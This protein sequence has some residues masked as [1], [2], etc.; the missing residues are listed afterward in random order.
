MPVPVAASPATAP[1]A[2]PSCTHGGGVRLIDQ[3]REHVS[4]LIDGLP[5]RDLWEDRWAARLRHEDVWQ[6]VRDAVADDRWCEPAPAATH[7]GNSSD[8]GASASIN[9]TGNDTGNNTG[10][11]T[12]VQSGDQPPFQK[13][14]RLCAP[15]S[16]Q[17]QQTIGRFING[18]TFSATLAGRADGCA[19]LVIGVPSGAQRLTSSGRQTTRMSVSSGSP[20]GKHVSVQI[21]SLASGTR[22]TIL[23]TS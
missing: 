21:D 11:D 1:G 23:W 15:T 19:D 12:G 2:P 20:L 10:N 17:D 7:R 5:V 8:E 9:N 14:F 18:H 22:V 6:Q 3:A 13:S 4:E 16:S